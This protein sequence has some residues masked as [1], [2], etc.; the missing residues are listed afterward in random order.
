MSIVRVPTSFNIDLEFEM[1][2]FHYRLFAWLIDVVLEIL[3]LVL[4][5]YFIRASVTE[6]DIFES[7]TTLKLLLLLFPL[8]IFFYHPL[9]EIFFNG[10]SV[11]KKIFGLRV[12]SEDGS[13]PSISQFIIRAIIRAA[14]LAIAAILVLNFAV[15]FDKSLRFILLASFLVLIADVILVAASRKSQRL[16]D[17]IAHTIVVSTRMR[18][19]MEESVFIEVA[20]NYVPVFPQIMNLSDSDINAIKSILDSA[21]KRSDYNLATIASEKIKNHLKIETSMSPFDFLETL[22]KDYNYLSVK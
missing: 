6:A 5:I 20:D 17:M 1:G 8:P 14:D 12:V 9:C 21:T 7:S 16:G 3:Y 11:G 2:E 4:A 22:M 13:R 15:L 10:Q 18:G 19:K